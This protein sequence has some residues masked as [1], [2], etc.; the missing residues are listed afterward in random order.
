M[1]YLKYVFGC[2]I[3][4]LSVFSCQ[5]DNTADFSSR[6]FVRI[7][8][9]SVVLS[10]G[11]KYTIK[12]SIDTLGSASK[13]FVWSIL[14]P[15]IASIAS[16]DN[17]TAVITAL[18]E[19][20]TV[21]KISSSDN[22]L[23]YF[24]NLSVSK[25]R[26]IKVLA[27]GGSLSDDAVEN[28][29]YD[30][31]QSAGK[32]III[33]NL[34][35]DKSSLADHWENA[36]Q[37]KNPYQFR[38]IGT[39]GTKNITNEITLSNAIKS[40]NWDYISFEENISVSGKVEGYQN[41]LPNLV[42]FAKELTTN[43]EVKFLLH[44][45]WAYAQNSNEEGFANYDNDQNKMYQAIV[46][47]VSN[48]KEAGSVD[49]VVPSGTAIQ[50]GR[51]TYVGDPNY[52]GDLFTQADGYHLSSVIGRLTA[53]A[54]WFETIFGE[55]V[56]NNVFEASQIS[57]YENN[58]LKTAAHSAVLNSSAVTPLTQY[59]YPEGFVLNNFVLKVPIY[60]DFGPV[61]S[62]APFNNYTKPTDPKITN[63]KD[64]NGTSTNFIIGVQNQFSGT[65]D[66]GLTNTLGFSTT[67]SQD[68]FFSDG[69][70][71]NF[72][73]SS[74]ALSNFNKDSKYTFVFYGAINDWNTETE[75]RV[76]GKNEGVAY[77]VNDYNASKV[78]IISGIS[79]TDYG[80]LLI[81]MRKGPHN[82]HWAGFFGINVMIITPDGYVLPG[83]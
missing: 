79:P 70:N 5:E 36:S 17:T 30:L 12:A 64:Q 57:T 3:I 37:N 73:V 33:G 14:D 22:E 46:N 1:K 9:Q 38:L 66:R 50:N 75:F 39:D 41:Y 59:R 13:T 2:L 78:A 68:M 6:H 74:F 28:Y 45:P 49:L 26:I 29:L 63:L 61:L 31:V 58:L 67:A 53:A 72:S 43:P 24:S 8:K 81:Q 7:N 20:T 83:M 82:T 69:N 11:E 48:A 47:A 60:I 40:Q 32:K 19:G 23:N 44:Q 34:Y 10:A 35:L 15:S 25:D 52:L 71:P 77:L 62:P 80:T 16:I 42:G 51:T 4:L 21:I 65:L 54:T 18:K 55:N 76:I 56:T 27:I